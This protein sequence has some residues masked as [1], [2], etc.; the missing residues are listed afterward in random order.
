MPHSDLVFRNDIVTRSESGVQMR[1]GLKNWE[2]TYD[3]RFKASIFRPDMFLGDHEFRVGFNRTNDEFGQEYPPSADLPVFNHS[4]RL[5]SGVPTELRVYNYHNTPKVVTN[6]LGFFALDRWQVGRLTLN[7]GARYGKDEAYAPEKCSEAARPPAHL[8][9]PARC[10]AEIGLPTRNEFDP[11]LSFA[12]DLTGNGKT[13]LK[14]GWGH[15]AYRNH[16]EDI[17]SLDADSPGFADYRWRD[18]NGNLDYDPGEVNLDPNGPDFITLSVNQGVANPD[19]KGP[20]SDEFMLSIERELVANLAVRALGVSSIARDNYRV[21]NAARPYET[22]NIPITN[23]DPGA[24]G[25][26]GTADD[27]GV[28]FTYWS[29]RPRSSGSSSCAR[30]SSTIPTSTRGTIA[31]SLGLAGDMPAAGTSPGRIGLPRRTSRSSQAA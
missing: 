9:F 4:L 2:S 11:R 29:I 8:I 10:F 12:I 7:L 1:S 23:P 14:G 19:L 3:T 16:H 27:P 30:R 28:N 17:V 18:L 20:S 24:D 15:Y 6:Y 5:A 25:R 31:S 26:V 22:Y 21:A 13:V